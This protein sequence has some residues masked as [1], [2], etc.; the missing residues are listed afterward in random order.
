MTVRFNVKFK[1]KA[2]SLHIYSM[3]I[4]CGNLLD[5]AALQNVPTNTRRLLTVTVIK[6]VSTTLAPTWIIPGT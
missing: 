3:C 4:F 1:A 2:K 5:L 6:L